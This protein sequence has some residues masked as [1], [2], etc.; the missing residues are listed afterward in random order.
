MITSAFI[1]TNPTDELITS[2]LPVTRTKTAATPAFAIATHRI[3]RPTA[4]K[5]ELF[6]GWASIAR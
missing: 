3:A 2:R 4:T 5:N 6:I 1:G